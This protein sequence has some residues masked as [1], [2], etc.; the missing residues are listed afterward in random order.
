[1]RTLV[2]TV[3]LV[4]ALVG[5]AALAGGVW[6]FFGGLSA[7]AAPGRLE[8]AVARRLRS[9]AIPTAARDSQNPI[10][11]TPETLRSGL[12][13]FADHCGVCHANDGSGD[14]EMG[15]NLYPPAPDMRQSATQSL[16]D[17]ELFYIIENGVR[18]T[19]MPAWSTGTKAGEEASWHLV[20]FI[21]H[22]PKITVAELEQMKALNPKSAAEWKEEEEIRRFLSGEGDRAPAPAPRRHEHGGEER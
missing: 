2:R 19:G 1:M 16:S 6:L 10:R 8:T 15:R 18:F 9:I 13:H 17:G 3:V 4:L 22:L 12:E 11:P 14:T 21:R 5:L 20:Q 7:R